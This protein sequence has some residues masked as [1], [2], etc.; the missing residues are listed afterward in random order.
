MMRD[1]RRA[2]D[3]GMVVVVEGDGKQETKPEKRWVW[4]EELVL[5]RRWL[6]PSW[7]AIRYGL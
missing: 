5:V 2:D 6:P 4:G 1:E 3:D 7:E